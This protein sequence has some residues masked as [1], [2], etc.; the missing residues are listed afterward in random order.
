MYNWVQMLAWPL[1]VILLTRTALRAIG[2]LVL[3][4]KPEEKEADN[5]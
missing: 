1:T 3:Y 5:A 2:V 4:L